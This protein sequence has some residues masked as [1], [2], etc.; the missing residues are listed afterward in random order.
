MF[1]GLGLD[2]IELFSV[3][4]DS[5]FCDVVGLEGNTLDVVPVLFECFT[6]IVLL[7]STMDPPVEDNLVVKEKRMDQQMSR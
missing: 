2:S 4:P 1:G 7:F 5:C 3:E 6:I